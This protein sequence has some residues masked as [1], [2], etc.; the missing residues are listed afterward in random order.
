[1]IFKSGKEQMHVLY[2]PRWY[3]NRYDPMPGLFIQR[4]GIAASSQV[5][6]S[7]LYVH[8]DDQENASP[9]NFEVTEEN[10]LFRVTVYAKRSK[11]RFSTLINLIRYLKAHRLGL[12]QIKK[13]RGEPDLVHVH[14]LTRLGIVACLYKFFTGTP[15]VITEHWT[16]YLPIR[17]EFK[18][19]FRKRITRFVVKK[20]GAVMPVSEDLQKAMSSHKLRNK[21]YIIV[22]NVVD[23]ELFKPDFE[24]HNL[25]KKF[26]HLSCFLDSHKNIS[27]ILN[28]LHKLS[29]NRND[30]ECI[31]IGDGPDYEYLQNYSKE[32]GLENIVTFTGLLEGKKLAE[33]LRQAD[34]MI[35]FSNHE[36]LPVVILESFACGIPVISSRVGG[37]H[38]H[39]KPERGQLIERGNEAELFEKLNTFL[40]KP[41]KYDKERIRK[42]ALDHFSNAVVGK[43][44]FD[45]YLSMIE[46]SNSVR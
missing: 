1:M 29:Q 45:I 43:Q 19:F 46:N 7:V 30:F 40:E 13:Y 44:L 42:Y 36:N 12:E 25:K 23:T 37:I 5:Y 2:L 8:M 38:E 28:V 4:H 16:R 9:Y 27:G 35:M 21:N 41:E 10:G 24:H 3:P 18:G 32:K 15:Y 17:K 6:V 31:M 34:A 39:L 26:I 20:A 11:A 14:V 33:Q 22:P